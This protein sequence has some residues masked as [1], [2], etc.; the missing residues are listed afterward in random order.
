MD[1]PQY[2]RSPADIFAEAEAAAREA[3]AAQPAPAPQP[4]NNQLAQEITTALQRTAE[5]QAQI[6]ARLQSL[7]QSVA[8]RP[9]SPHTQTG[10]GDPLSELE[11]ESGITRDR[12]SSAFAPLAA[13]AAEQVFED[14]FGP[15]IRAGEALQQ[16]AQTHE[17]FDVNKFNDYVMKNPDVAKLVNAASNKGAF[18]TAI[19]YGETRRQL[20]ERISTEARG[21][22]KR[23]QR[24]QVV[25]A[26]RPDAQVVGA[27]G[28]AAA[29]RNVGTQPLT[30]S[31]VESIYAHANA[32]NWKPFEERFHL[33]NLPP[34]EWWQQLAQ[35]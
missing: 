22:S 3:A 28:A 13:K 17:G 4:Q 5:T 12:W 2:Q 14:K 1:N 35:S 24:K 29:S 7:E 8:Q 9:M 25:E 23:E 20:D 21:A 34:E 15:T 26:T 11:R 19:E 33:S 31:E 18:E 27:S 6:A 30:Q 10:G 32:N 16:Y